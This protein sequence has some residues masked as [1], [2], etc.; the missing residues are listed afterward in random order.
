M[1]DFDGDGR[2]DVFVA[3]DTEPN[4]L[5]RNKGNGTFEDRGASS[6]ASRSARPAWRAPAWASTRSTTTARDGPASSIGNFSNQMMALY[7]NEGNG[8]FIDDAPRSTI[9]RSSL[10]A[11]TFGCFFF[12]YDLDG[13][14]TSSRRTA[15]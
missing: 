5:Y 7:H 6:R 1:L 4:R 15:T 2:M 9:G 14:P 8:L 3:N 12:D 11:L 10:L 13:L